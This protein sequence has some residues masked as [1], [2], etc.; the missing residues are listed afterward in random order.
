MPTA[1]NDSVGPDSNNF[2]TCSRDAQ[3]RE[4]SHADN[5]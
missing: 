2:L 5:G 4:R 1:V 3:T